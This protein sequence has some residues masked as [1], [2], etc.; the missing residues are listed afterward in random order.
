MLPL[1]NGIGRHAA[2]AVIGVAGH[3][4]AVGNDF[5]L[6]SIGFGDRCGIGG[7][8]ARCTGCK[9]KRKKEFGC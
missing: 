9:C 8:G 7:E 2:R 1:Q 4:H 5:A 3:A 6:G